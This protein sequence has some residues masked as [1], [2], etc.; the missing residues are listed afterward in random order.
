MDFIAVQLL[1][2]LA[3]ASELFLVASGLSLIFGVT[4]I[5]NFAHGSLFMLGAYLCVTLMARLPAGGGGFWAGVLAAAAL[6]AVLGGLMEILVLRRLYAAPELLQLLATFA[7]TLI[8]QDLV[9]LLWGPEDLLGPQA[10]GLAGTVAVLGPPVPAYDLLLVGLGPLVLAALWLVLRSTRFG[11]LIRAES[12]DREMLAC[13]G[14]HQARLLTLVFLLGSLLA[15]L[16]CALQVPRQPVSHAMDVQVIVEAFVVVVIGGLGSITGA[17][18]ASVLIGVLNAFAIVVWPESSLVLIFLVMALVLAVRPHGL[19]GRPQPAAAV[20]RADDRDQARPLQPLSAGARTATVMA[21]A[22]LALLPL[23]AG[24]YALWVAAEVL[25]IALFAA[26]LHLLIGSGGLVS[27]GHAAYFGIGAY[28]AAL[29]TKLAAAPMA[30]ALA[31]GPVAAGIAGWIFGRLCGRLAG[32]Y[33]AMLTLAY[34]Q[35]FWSVAFQ[36]YGVTGGDNG[37]LGIWPAPALSSPAAF[38]LLTLALAGGALILLRQLAFSP[39]GFSL[40]A[41]RDSSLRA[42]A[43]GISRAATER[44]AFVMAGTA[45]GLA[46]ALYAFLKGS[47]FPDAL[48]IALSVEG[49][50]MVLLGGLHS[51]SGPI[52]G[53]A[54][55]KTLQVIISA[56]TDQWRLVLGGIVLLLILALPDG[57]LGMRRWFHRRGTAP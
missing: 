39:F 36:W 46:G 52:A 19:L 53:A 40:R 20:P 15:G 6:V 37:L 56:A 34:A 32:V 22:A 7:I 18:L 44:R 30:L 24:D 14:G 35:L 48:G 38:Y 45:A 51:L 26:S 49:L 13:L 2:G 9:I 16:G 57:L 47:I 23:L 11:L 27:F 42:E 3:S 4:R 50:V 54:V 25:I 28:T 5:V 1:N 29:A 41:C 17:Y 43:V 55:F 31:A 8:V 10:P 21:L 33:L 12:E